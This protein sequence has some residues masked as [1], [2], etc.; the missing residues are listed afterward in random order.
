VAG[1]VLA[2]LLAAAPAGAQD[3]E[4][5]QD[6]ELRTLVAAVDAARRGARAPDAGPIT[7][8]P[9]YLKGGDD[10]TYVPFTLLIDPAAVSNADGDVTD[11]VVAYVAMAEA[12]SDSA[13]LAFENGFYA[14]AGERE[15]DRLR[16][17]G[18]LQAEG[19]DYD[20]YIAVRYSFDGEAPVEASIDAFGRQSRATVVPPIT[21]LHERVA[22][23]DLWNDELQTSTVILTQS[24]RQLTQAPSE[25]EL[26]RSPYMVGANL[27]EP[28]LNGDF[29]K[30][31]LLGFVF[32][33]YNTGHSRGMPDITVAY[34]F[35]T[36][37]D[38]DDEFFNRTDPRTFNDQ[39]L[40][41]GFDVRQFQ[42]MDGL[43]IP[44]GGFPAGDYRLEIKVT[45]NRED[46]EVTQNLLFSVA[47]N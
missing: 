35:Y 6:A 46:E 36:R 43:D 5:W 9:S 18:N 14:E 28:R 20:L 19:G 24:V 29:T 41:P 21:V 4:D 3:L 1:C 34:E 27:V 10:L 17:P 23:P 12:G 42:L 47:D 16:I 2:A 26:A 11:N 39:T 25:D 40:P 22:I 33:I 7:Y 8:L 31:D 13:D 37:T 15:G 44:L 32:A 30:Q 45:D 38:G